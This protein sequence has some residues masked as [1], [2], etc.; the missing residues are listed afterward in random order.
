MNG[1]FEDQYKRLVA[2]IETI[3]SGAKEF[4]AH[5]YVAWRRLNLAARCRRAVAARVPR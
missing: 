1:A 2:E 5:G 4:H 3:Y